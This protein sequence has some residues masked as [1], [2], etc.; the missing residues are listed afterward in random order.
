MQTNIQTFFPSL[1]SPALENAWPPP[2]PPP[3]SSTSGSTT[4]DGRVAKAVAATAV[5]TFVFWGL[6]FFLL[7]LFL[8]RRQQ[9][10]RRQVEEEE[11]EKSRPAKISLPEGIRARAS[12]R[13]TVFVDEDGLDAAYWREFN[14]KVDAVHGD[15]GESRSGRRGDD[16]EE[17]VDLG[18]VD[19]EKKKDPRI[20][21]EP[22]LPAG[23]ISSSSPI[24]DDRSSIST[25]FDRENIDQ[26]PP[27]PRNLGLPPPPGRLPSALRPPAAPPRLPSPARVSNSKLQRPSSAPRPATTASEVRNTRPPRP[28]SP[29]RIVFAAPRPA[30][31]PPEVGNTGLSRTPLPGRVISSPSLPATVKSEVSSTS[32]PT[33]PTPPSEPGPKPN[34]APPPPLLPSARTN[35]P[36]P[37]PPPP[38]PPTGNPS[39]KAP[40]PPP[41]RPPT[42]KP[43]GPAPPPPPPGGRPSGGSSRPPS[44]PGPASAVQGQGGATK[45]K[46]LHWDKMN[47]IN[48]EHSMVWDRLHNGS[49][50]VDEDVMEALFGT[51]I[52]NR[53][54]KAANNSGNSESTAASAAAF[55]PITL[56][57]PRKSQN[58]AIVLRSTTVSRQAIIEG[59]VDG[60]GLSTD[61]LER[62]TK[63]APTKDEED[64]IRAYSG[65]PGML[66][67]AENFLFHVLRAVPASPFSRLDAMLFRANYEPELAHLKQTLRTLEAAC[68][69]LR[70]PT[71]G[72]FLKLLETVLK[73]GNRMNAG[74]A[75]GNAQAFNLTALRK[76]ADV[77]STDGST[78]LLH[79]VVEEVVRSEGK[80]LVI[81]NRS[82]GGGTLERVPSRSSSA[83]VREEREREYTMLGLPLVGGLS[84]EF[85]NLKKAAGSD[86]DAFK[87][88]C[89]TLQA[90]VAEIK[91]LVESLSARGEISGGFVK[92]M[93]AFVEGAEEELKATVSEQ[94]RVMEV[95]KKTNE[96][97]HPGAGKERDGQPLQL[98]VVVKDFLDMVDKA[99]VD[100]TRNL[101]KKKQATA[102]A[103]RSGSDPT[104]GEEGA[105]SRRPV[106]R[107]PNLPAHFLK[108]NSKSDSSSDEE[109]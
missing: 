42:G 32:T 21:E 51:V 10:R 93:K 50:K 67:D 46:P 52:T 70:T 103:A 98:F 3:P 8:T 74:T 49:F 94:R 95:V 61:D 4:D 53:N 48:V 71:Q 56:L 62:L 90:R 77:K 23:F 72:L 33:P 101:Q 19:E 64:V 65:D 85:A 9:R 108:S 58:I 47:A 78:S 40:P 104:T 99:C 6:L 35:N 82:H 92:E 41:P 14:R 107:F 30:I 57:D 89:P 87:T 76:L 81:N 29:S 83:A 2:P 24:F 1:P 22:L 20:Q 60:R 59:V 36:A 84:N 91:R 80:R 7:H 15:L 73:A 105:E 43:P 100:I 37:N 69:E 102:A 97:Y 39:A 106:A 109:D 88:A 13:Q 34:A 66:A 86:Y 54:M 96:Y 5:S 25:R 55:I 44:A 12:K 31:V 26:N 16:D 18:D 27:P 11:A 28:P 68:A 38:P 45:L 79:F 75:R 63:I 17:S